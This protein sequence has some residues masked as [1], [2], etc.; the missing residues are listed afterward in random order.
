MMAMP[1][2]PRSTLALYQPDA[3]VDLQV[4]D[5]TCS[6]ESV[7]WLLR[8]LG[9]SPDRGNTRD[10]PWLK[11]QLVPGYVTPELG[12]LDA[13][14]KSLSVWLQREYGDDMGL[15]IWAINPVTWDDL[16]TLVGRRPV[17]LGGR[18]WN[19]WSG[20]RRWAGEEIELANPAPNWQGVGTRMSRAEFDA[21]GPF[22]AITAFTREEVEAP[23]LP[24]EPQ[25]DAAR[26]KELEK[27]LADEIS[28]RGYLTG[29][30]ADAL[31]AIVD[32]LW[33]HKPAA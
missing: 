13:S 27:K 22:S 14:G 17:I 23:P 32:T 33:H 2:F 9:R 20:A 29:D 5:W 7:Q 31:Q 11:G 6:I 28:T 26:I 1:P 24:V 3:P 8:A 4:L 10:D 12:L 18:A 30:V 15:V 16:K 21:Q 19:H 25:D